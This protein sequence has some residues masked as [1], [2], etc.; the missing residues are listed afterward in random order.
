MTRN[1]G[2]VQRIKRKKNT[3]KKN[4]KT[5]LIGVVVMIYG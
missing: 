5:M 2:E 3:K 4:M 1:N